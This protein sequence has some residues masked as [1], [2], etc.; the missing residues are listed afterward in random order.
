MDG[1]SRLSDS[2]R[3]VVVSVLHR[4]HAT[5]LHRSLVLQAWDHAHGVDRMVVVGVR[6]AGPVAPFGAHA[7]LDG[8]EPDDREGFVPLLRRSP[9]GALAPERPA[10]R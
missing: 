2:E 4:T 1:S 3:R 10:D 5:C 6:P 7:W 8:D 9:A